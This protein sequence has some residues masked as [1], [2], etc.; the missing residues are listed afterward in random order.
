MC[1]IAIKPADK[2][3]FTDDQ[4]KVMFTNNPDGAG[5]MYYHKTAG[6]VAIRKGFMDVESLLKY[7]HSRDFTGIN[8]ILHFR[9]S[10]SGLKDQLNCHPF[11]VYGDN[12]IEMFTKMG[13]AHNGILREYEP[14]KK[15][16]I[17][18]TQVFIHSVL[19]NLS[20]KFIYSDDKCYLLRELI[21]T[22][23]LAFLDQKNHVRLIGDFIRDNGYIYSNASY[24]PKKKPAP[25]PAPVQKV[26]SLADTDTTDEGYG[27]YSD[28]KGYVREPEDIG[29]DIWKYLDEKL[30]Y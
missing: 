11:S 5:L 29:E 10:T 24:K 9:I 26:F 30:G 15:S 23:K 6:R 16:L 28:W 8:V 22:N 14:S 13:V 17:N 2:P 1:I 27:A 3:M 19:R 18:D 4:I 21:G 12:K 20:P 7:L 25:K